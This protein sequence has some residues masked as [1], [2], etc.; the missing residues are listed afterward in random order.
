MSGP[1]PW[2]LRSQVL[3]GALSLMLCLLS[4]RPAP[5]PCNPTRLALGAGV[6]VSL[7]TGQR[8]K[9]PGV[10]FLSQIP[11]TVVRAYLGQPDRWREG[12]PEQGPLHPAQP[13]S[14]PSRVQEG[15]PRLMLGTQGRERGDCA[16]IPFPNVEIS[17]ARG[18]AVRWVGALREQESDALVLPT[19]CPWWVAWAPGVLSGNAGLVSF[20]EQP[21]YPAVMPAEWPPCGQ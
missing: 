6:G 19:D 7:Q 9:S 11:A 5:A 14:A 4:P 21:G 18:R 17:A 13:A 20:E 15:S 8:L 3:S 1:H 16:G 2:P 12:S 10:S